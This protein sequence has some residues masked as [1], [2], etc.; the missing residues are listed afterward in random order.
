MAYGADPKLFKDVVIRVGVPQ[1]RVDICEE[2]YELISLAF[3]KLIA[4]HIDPELAK[5]VYD[6]SWLPDK[7]FDLPNSKR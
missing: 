7:N 2:E 5:K 1:Y 4:P 6:R 3:Q